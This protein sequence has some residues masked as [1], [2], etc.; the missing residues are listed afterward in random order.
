MMPK[1]DAH[2]T[3]MMARM[4]SQIEKM[5][6][7]D[8]MDSQEKLDTIADKQ[9]VPKREAM[10]ETIGALVDQCWYWH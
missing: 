4:D 2:Y 1:L 5:N 3:R 6:T 7:T 10:V 8:L 9:D